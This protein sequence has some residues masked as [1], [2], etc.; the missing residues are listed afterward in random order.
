ME[1]DKCRQIYGGVGS[2]MKN[3]NEEMTTMRVQRNMVMKN[4]EEDWPQIKQDDTTVTING[5]K[6]NSK[7]RMARNKLRKSFDEETWTK[8]Q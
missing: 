3:G 8:N 1:R 6:K 2:L 7:K 4:R 5:Q